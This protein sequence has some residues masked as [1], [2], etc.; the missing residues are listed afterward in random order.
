MLQ[1][2]TLDEQIPKVVGHHPFRSMLGWIDTHDRKPLTANFLDTR[3]DDA[4]WVL[5]GLSGI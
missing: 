2:L 4:I 3:P 5:E 1:C